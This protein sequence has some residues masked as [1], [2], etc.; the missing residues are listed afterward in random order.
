MVG[1]LKSMNLRGSAGQAEEILSEILGKENAQIFAHDLNAF[2]RPP[3]TS[4]TLQPFDN[5][6][7]YKVRRQPVAVG[8]VTIADYG[9]GSYSKVFCFQ[10]LRCTWRSRQTRF[11]PSTGGFKC[12]RVGSFSSG[13]LQVG[14]CHSR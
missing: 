3:C 12:L 11:S 6:A 9:S 4:T 8:E 7:Q 10:F 14:R 1:I 5:F 13:I 2:V